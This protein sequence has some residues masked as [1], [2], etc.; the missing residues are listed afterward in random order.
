MEQQEPEKKKSGRPKLYSTPEEAKQAHAI[1]VAQSRERARDRQ[2][3]YDPFEWID[4]WTEKYS[5]QHEDLMDFV[6]QT[7]QTI[8]AELGV[9]SLNGVVEEFTI[10][11]LLI[12][13]Y[14]LRQEDQTIWCRKVAGGTVVSGALFLDIIGGELVENTH[15]TNL[16]R[17][18]TYSALYRELIQKLDDMFGANGDES[19]RAVKLERSG[20]YVLKEK[21]KPEER[22]PISVSAPVVVAPS[23]VPP[24]ANVHL[25]FQELNRSLDTAALS[26]LQGT[27]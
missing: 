6:H 5:R 23:P 14:G 8:A 2:R 10:R 25:A 24:P 19:S 22:K 15:R 11:S 20:S 21:P 26:Y 18:K 9:E 13:A 4:G 16:E 3:L 1:Q 12:C 17:S 7:E 27:I